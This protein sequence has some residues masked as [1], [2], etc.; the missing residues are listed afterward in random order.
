MFF[1]LISF[2]G[3]KEFTTF[4]SDV[5]ATASARHTSRRRQIPIVASPRHRARCDR[6]EARA[7]IV[8]LIPCCLVR[9][10]T[11]G[12]RPPD[13]TALSFP[14]CTQRSISRSASASPLAL[15]L[16]HGSNGFS[17][18]WRTTFAIL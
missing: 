8:A 1:A 16:Y 9:L 3:E 15:Q 4:V 13:E 6:H 10:S 5:I 18:A 2:S 14:A 12:L 7:G 11:G 17:H